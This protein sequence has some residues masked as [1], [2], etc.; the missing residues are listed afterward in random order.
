MDASGGVLSCRRTRKYPKKSAQG[1]RYE[2]KRPPLGTPPAASRHCGIR[3]YVLCRRL[4]TFR[5]F[6]HW[7]SSLHVI[8]SPVYRS[9][10]TCLSQ[11]ERCP[12]KGAERVTPS[13]SPAVTALPEGELR[14]R[15]LR[16]VAG[17]KRKRSQ[18]GALPLRLSKNRVIANQPEGWCGDLPVFAGNPGFLTKKCCFLWG[19]P[20]QCDHWLAMTTFLTH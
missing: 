13:Q 17:Q 10:Q 11:R 18:A 19:L 4:G 16:R 5:K 1:R 20:R 8:V 12:R 7:Y 2:Q 15:S 6:F 3:N 9:S 14:N